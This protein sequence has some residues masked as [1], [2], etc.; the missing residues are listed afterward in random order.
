VEIREE[1]KRMNK[2][3]SLSKIDQEV[4]LTVQ[5][6]VVAKEEQTKRTN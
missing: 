1:D 6:N 5:K 4:K 3:E 2:K